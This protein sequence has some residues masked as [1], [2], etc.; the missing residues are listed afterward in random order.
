M[1]KRDKEYVNSKINSEGFG[2]T[3]IDYSNFDD[4]EDEKFHE[5]RMAYIKAHEDLEKYLGYEPQ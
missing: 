5:L 3:F 2:Y 4:I 1:N